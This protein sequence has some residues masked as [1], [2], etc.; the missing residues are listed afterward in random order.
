MKHKLPR[1]D[2][3]CGTA[4]ACAIAPLAKSTA[5]E[6]ESPEKLVIG[7][8]CQIASGVQFITASANHRYDGISTVPFAVF[9]PGEDPMAR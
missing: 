8:F 2:L 5:A 4:A 9:D 1:R 3:L 6:K 7:K